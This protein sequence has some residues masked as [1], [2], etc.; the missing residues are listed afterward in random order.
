MSARCAASSAR[1]S[2]QYSIP[3]RW[4][5]LRRRPA[6]SISRN[7][8]SPRS[9][10]VSIASRVVP[11]VGATIT[12]GRPRMAFTSDDLPTF[13]R[14]RMATRISSSASAPSPSSPSTSGGGSRSTIASSRSPVPRPC[15]ADTLIGSPRPSP[16][17]SSAPASW[18][19]SSTLFAS[20]STGRRDRRRMSASS[21]SPATRPARASMTSS[22]RSASSTAW[23]AWSATC[24]CM[25]EGSAASTPP[26][27]TRTNSRPFQSHGISFRSRV[28]PGVSSTTA[29]REPVSRLTR[30][31]FPAFG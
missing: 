2:L 19:V 5:R 22:T 15:S 24:D 31:D 11:G 9:K 17:S 14:P 20:T 4:R 29:L 27:S 1:T 3:W 13:G 26:V 28:T 8:R 30:V 10:I 23:R 12:R 18:A 21:S 7:R 16:C 6:V 25:C